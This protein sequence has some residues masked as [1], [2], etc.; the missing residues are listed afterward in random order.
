ML[1]I[2]KASYPKESMIEFLL[3]IIGFLG[4]TLASITDL[5]KREVPDWLSY[6]M[7]FA[8]LGSRALESVLLKDYLPFLT[9]LLAF[10]A[11]FVIANLFYYTKQW[12]GGDSKLLMGVGAIFGNGLPISGLTSPWPFLALFILNLFIAGS[13]YGLFYTLGLSIKHWKRIKQELKKQNRNYF[14]FALLAFLL[15]LSI[16][17]FLTEIY[18]TLFLI[19]IVFVY[20]FFNLYFF[21][22]IVEK[23]SMQSWMN[24]EK[25]TEGDWVLNTVKVGSKTICTPKDLGL[26]KKQIE[27]LKK[28]GIKKVLVKEGI[29]FVPAFFFALLLTLFWT[30]LTSLF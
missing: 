9:G 15:L 28:H 17:F 19:S 16:S 21:V 29:P 6:G 10:G 7:I 20:F 8:G 1:N 12:G 14:L 11:A 24:V 22:K 3:L 5:K 23:I 26:E 25:L 27:L 2:K 18:Q 4:I 13:L 30:H